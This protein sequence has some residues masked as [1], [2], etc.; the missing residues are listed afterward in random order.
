MAY[1]SGSG[2]GR[3]RVRVRVSQSVPI[4]PCTWRTMTPVG[5]LAPLRMRVGFAASSALSSGGASALGAA[6]LMVT[7]LQL[8]TGAT[9]PPSMQ[10]GSEASALMVSEVL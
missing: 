4:Q 1:G 8:Q 3:V 5:S 6:S 9:S 10:V 2:S 7:M